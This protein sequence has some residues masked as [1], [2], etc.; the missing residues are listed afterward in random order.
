MHWADVVTKELLKKS[1][2]HR[3]AT[4][5]S[6]SGPIHLGNLREMV[7][8]DAIKKSL[9][10]AGGYAEIIYIADD[11]DQLRKR[12]PFLPKEYEEFVGKPLCK[13]PDPEGCHNSYSEH[14]LE[15]FLKSL[16]VLGIETKVYRASE[17]YEKGEYREVIKVA[18]ERR[19]DIARI[20]SEVTGRK[21]EKDWSPFMPICE[22]CGRIITTK[23][24]D[25]DESGICYICSC[26]SS[27]KVSY[28]GGGKL[29]WRVDWAARWKILGITCEP[30]G[31]DHAAAGGSYDTGVR[32]SREIYNYEPPY[33]V[34][35]EWVHIKGLG[36]AK[37][38]RG[39]IVAVEDVVKAFPPEIIRYLF[40]RIR[41]EKHIEFEPVAAL[42]LF[43]E[44]EEKLKRRE[45]D[46]ELS[47]VSEVFYSEVP[48]RHIVIVG[49][50]ANWDLEKVV[51]IL[52]RN[53]KVDE[54][55]KK[56]IERKL[57]YAKNWI[58]KFAS[59]S[60]KFKIAEKIDAKLEEDEKK[61]LYE[62]VKRLDESMD[63]E[64]IHNLVYVVARENNVEASKAFRAIYKVILNRDHG[65]RAGYFI[66]SLGIDWIKERV[67]KICQE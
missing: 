7:T 58:E 63:A 33:P 15:P 28:N 52:S 25:F 23:V 12:Y 24:T 32:I 22:R 60:M 18:L 1:K 53:Y 55:T 29:T 26:G 45:E 19:E 43:D 31:K 10:K 5:I 48:F 8:A 14:F 66:K 65:P 3:I 61:F 6:P 46:A 56:D 44:F 20:I 51:Q 9:C 21:I 50:I 16:D 35:Y 11:V 38:S 17:M 40:I 4:G 54:A 37:K 41:P 2:K 39:I 49:Q 57:Q 36:V 64:Q 62:F 42:D 47:L 59:E 30:F 27:G 34:P 67:S 13:I